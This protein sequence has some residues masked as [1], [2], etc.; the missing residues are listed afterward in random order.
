MELSG[1][2]CSGHS[3]R[4]KPSAVHWLAGSSFISMSEEP[5]LNPKLLFPLSTIDLTAASLTALSKEDIGFSSQGVC[6]CVVCVFT[7]GE[8]E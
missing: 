5:K 4:V 6:M 1:E 2:E 7:R 3:V 8:P